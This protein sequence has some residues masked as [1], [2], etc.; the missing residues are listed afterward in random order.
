[1]STPTEDP[2]ERANRYLTNFQAAIARFVPVDEDAVVS[3]RG[4]RRVSDT[5][6]RY[7]ND[8]RYYMKN[9][10]AVTALTS[11]A[12]AEGLMDALTFLGLTKTQ[13]IR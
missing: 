12:Y 2:N 8:A 11:V 10:K 6:E 3:E 13:V 4:I 1:M 9:G 5:I 7:F